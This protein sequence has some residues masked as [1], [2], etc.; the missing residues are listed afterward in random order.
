MWAH[1]C[2]GLGPQE[3]PRAPGTGTCICRR[4]WWLLVGKTP[5]HAA[6]ALPGL[7]SVALSSAFHSQDPVGRT[8]WPRC[9]NRGPLT[10]GLGA[11]GAGGAD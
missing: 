2:A 11:L 7:H 1:G 4:V 5:W 9:S 6:P 10:P 3:E 8:S